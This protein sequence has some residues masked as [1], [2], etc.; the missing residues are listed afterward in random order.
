MK[1]ARANI[2]ALYGNQNTV[3]S[4]IVNH[5]PSTSVL[6]YFVPQMVGCVLNIGL[7]KILGIV[8]EDLYASIAG[9]RLDLVDIEQLGNG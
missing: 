6:A 7:K 9:M 5:M 3:K 2:K 8:K 1:L 4:L